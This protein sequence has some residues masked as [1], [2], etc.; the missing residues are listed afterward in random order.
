VSGVGGDVMPYDVLISKGST[1][2]IDYASHGPLRCVTTVQSS[3]SLLPLML[4]CSPATPP[5]LSQ[6]YSLNSGFWMPLPGIDGLYDV[7]QLAQSA[8]KAV[9]PRYR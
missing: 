3:L 5:P 9:Q 2:W 4:V 1:W 7:P 6:L 8:L